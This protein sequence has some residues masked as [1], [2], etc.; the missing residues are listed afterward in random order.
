MGKER[1]DLASDL[2]E[3]GY[4]DMTVDEMCDNFENNIHRIMDTC[5]PHRMTS[6][7]YNDLWFNR[8]LRR[9]IRGKQL[10]YDKAKKSRNPTYWNDFRTARKRLHKSLKSAR[11]NYISDY[12]ELA[13]V[14]NPKRFWSYIKELKNDDP[15]VADFKVHGKIISDG[16]LKA[17][18]LSNHFSSVFTHGDL[19]DIQLL[20]LI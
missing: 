3:T 8:A 20:V 4:S 1:I 12:L 2:A 17:E 7:R 14:E 16:N 11:E 10:L 19:T 13:I 6:S 5:I 18:L 15:G 9:Q